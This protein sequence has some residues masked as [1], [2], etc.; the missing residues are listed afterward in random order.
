MIFIF[1]NEVQHD[2][3]C[4]GDVQSHQIQYAPERKTTKTRK[5]SLLRVISKVFWRDVL[6]A[7]LL[8]VAFDIIQFV[9]PQ[10][11]E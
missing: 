9:Q 7:S 5:P 6:L 3:C 4:P 8:K 10:I 1:R 11:L 2:R